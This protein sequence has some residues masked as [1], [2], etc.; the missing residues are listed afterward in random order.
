MAHWLLQTIGIHPDLWEPWT[1]SP[2]P[3]KDL[4]YDASALPWKDFELIE[5]HNA[6]I[7]EMRALEH[8]LDESFWR[9]TLPSCGRERW[10]VFN[11]VMDGR[12]PS[13]PVT[14]IAEGSPRYSRNFPLSL[15]LSEL[16]ARAQLH[17]EL[18]RD[19]R[20]M[21]GHDHAQRCLPVAEDQPILRAFNWLTWQQ[22]LTDAVAAFDILADWCRVQG[23]PDPDWIIEELIRAHIHGIE[24]ETAIT[25]LRVGQPLAPL[26]PPLRASGSGPHRLEQVWWQ[27]LAALTDRPTRAR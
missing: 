17:Q 23:P 25:R 22:P 7:D 3:S 12:S 19:G 20:I 14:S 15:R 5:E 10:F 16:R 6:A 1:D 2:D 8:D 18:V 13:A 26:T 4:L 9:V 11:H 24:L 27:A 21:S